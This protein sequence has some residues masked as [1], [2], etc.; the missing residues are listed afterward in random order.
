[1]PM[2]VVTTTSACPAACAGVVAVIVVAATVP[3]TAGEPPMVT[4]V[5]PVKFSPVMVT[6]VPPAIGPLA[7]LI[8]VTIGTV[9]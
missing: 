7:G 4:D 8:A 1:M 3:I 9:P 5:A 6:D 2:G